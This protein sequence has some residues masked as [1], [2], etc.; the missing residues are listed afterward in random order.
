MLTLLLEHGA[1]VNLRDRHGQ[2]LLQLAESDQNFACAQVLRQYGAKLDEDG[3]SA[4]AGASV[5]VLVKDRGVEVDDVATTTGAEVDEINESES[6]PET[7][8]GDIA[9]SVDFYG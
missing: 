7:G 8:L 6:E 2:T 9:A 4:K 5:D 3:E 1:D